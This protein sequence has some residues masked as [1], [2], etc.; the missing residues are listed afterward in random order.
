M[1][2][3][4]PF[5]IKSEQ[6]FNDLALKIFHF[7]KKNCAPYARFLEVLNRPEPN[8]YQEI[9]CLPISAFKQHKVYASDQDPACVFTSSGTTGMIPSRHFVKD[10]ALYEKSFLTHFERVYGSVQ[11]LCVLALLP[12]YLER[13]GSSLVH[14][15]ERLIRL[16]AHSSSGFFLHDYDALRAKLTQL[17]S[18]GQRTLLIGVSFALLDF[19]EA[20]P[21]SF[22]EL[23]VMETGGMKG[24]KKE[25]LREELHSILKKGFAVSS[26]HSEYGMTEL[27]SQAYAPSFGRF[28]C[29]A[30][31]KILVRDLNDPFA[32]LPAEHSG[33][34]NV[35]DLANM[36]SCSFIS[37][38]DL[39]RLH[40]D[41]SFE[42]LGRFDHSDMRGCSLMV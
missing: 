4:D 18:S 35:I 29:P 14:M 24:R 27:L 8:A 17:K 31:M 1:F 11:E 36:H 40:H 30:W 22:P 15:A 21:L 12:S 38:E 6:E 10:A 32:L 19:I 33:G 13:K 39:G 9:P 20:S 41:G 26:I 42:V 7:Q 28:H 2:D 5:Q 16:S 23:I 37:T 25:M 3:T 34:M